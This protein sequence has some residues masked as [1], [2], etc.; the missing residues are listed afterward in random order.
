[1]RSTT[2]LKLVIESF[3]TTD[4]SAGLFDLQGKRITYVK[5]SGLAKT[6][7]PLHDIANGMYVLR[8]KTSRLNKNKVIWVFK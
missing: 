1:M 6:N 4:Y 7:I 5:A 2:G 8:L 3:G